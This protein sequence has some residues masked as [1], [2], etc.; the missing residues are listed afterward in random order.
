MLFFSMAW[1]NV[2]RNRRRSLLT[3]LAITLG[4]S[5]NIFMRGIGDGFHEQMV[6][7]SV[8]SE[9]GHIE[10]H[11]AGYHDEPGLNKTLPNPEA[12]EKIVG[13]LPELR[14][15]SLRVLVGGLASTAENSSG[16]QILGVDP[17]QEQT[18]TTIQRG[19]I[20]GR[21]LSDEMQRPI[22]IGDRLATRLKVSLDDKVV[23]MVQA[24]DGSM[25]AELFRVAG[26]FRSGAPEM[27]EGV[28]FILRSDAQNIFALGNRVTEVALLLGSSRQVAS[29][30]ETLKK[31]LKGEPVEV[32]PWWQV[33][34]FL[35]QFIQIDDAF[36]YIIVL[37]FFIV[38]SIGILN[39]IMMSI[40]E[41]IREF[42]VMMALGTKPRQ[43]IKLVVEE[44]FVLGIVGVA[45]GSLLG[46]A[47]TLYFARHGINLSSFSAG[48]A[49]LGITS[50]R[51]YSELTFVN[52]LYSN[53]A[54]LIV[55][56]LVAFYPAIH[57][58][59]LRPVEALRHV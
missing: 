5:F 44:A 24:A 46:S 32:L 43:V 19:I 56:M 14:G 57:A 53:L 15:Y 50:S 13:S 54:V 20:K 12:V 25:G 34:P 40:F 4:L 10:I 52:L 36:F 47:L 28:V 37:I 27:D 45:S 33:E 11:R 42:G 38:I 8:R 26:I 59:R 55:V 35:Q 23:L 48:A 22:L 17:S 41:R 2:W 58:A 49:A 30:L 16:V 7:N 1:R 3:V 51:V 9:I 18:V 39:T 21:Y 29:A 31:D 6:D